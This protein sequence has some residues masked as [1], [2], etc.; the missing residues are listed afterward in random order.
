M[1]V[2]PKIAK[3]SVGDSM[4]HTLCLNGK[5]D[6]PFPIACFVV[7]VAMVADEVGTLYYYD[8]Q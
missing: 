2:D 1:T 8:Q 7:L 5:Y 4:A 6:T 3:C